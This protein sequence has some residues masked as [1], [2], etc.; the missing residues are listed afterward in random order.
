MASE[1]LEKLEK[2]QSSSPK[3]A[4]KMTLQRA[5]ELGEYDPEYLS[6]FPDWHT[7]SAHVQL[8]FIKSGLDNRERQLVLQWAEICNVIDFSLKP[9]LA[10]ALRN[11]EKQ[12]KQLG[13]D[14]ERLYLEYSRK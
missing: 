13:A 1:V 4:T 10:E 11:V 8:Q 3:S 6:T 12:L 7:L 5:V 2:A 14:R 9:H